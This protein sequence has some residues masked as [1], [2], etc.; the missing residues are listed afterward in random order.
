MR[1]IVTWLIVV[2]LF[3]SLG[4]SSTIEHSTK[5]TTQNPQPTI[6]SIVQHSPPKP[7]DISSL[8]RLTVQN[9]KTGMMKK[10]TRTEDIENIIKYANSLKYKPVD[11]EIRK[12]GY[13]TYE[14]QNISYRIIFEYK[15]G[16]T[17]KLVVLN[18]VGDTIFYMGKCYQVDSQAEAYTAELYKNLDYPEFTIKSKELFQK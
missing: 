11:K 17:E 7:I 14:E 5:P 2:M 1:L 4:C 6:D 10:V 18:I 15:G 12:K 16:D 13:N 9:A 3:A 8:G